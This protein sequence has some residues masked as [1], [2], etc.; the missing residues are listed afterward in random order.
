[1]STDRFSIVARYMNGRTV[2]GYKLLNLSTNR[3]CKVTKDQLCFLVGRKCVYNC[4]GQLYEDKVILRGIGGASL[5]K[6]PVI[7]E[8][9][10]KLSNEEKIHKPYRII[11]CLVNGRNTVGYELVN[12]EGETKRVS[13]KQ[14]MELAEVGLIE[15]ARVQQSNGERIL[16]GVNTN[17]NSLPAISCNQKKR[18]SIKDTLKVLGMYVNSDNKVVAFSLTNTKT[19]KKQQINTTALKQLVHDGYLKEL[20]TPN[21][22]LDTEKIK[23]LPRK[24][25]Q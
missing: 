12:K 15:N 8:S 20:A 22:D 13:R 25:V 24:R 10:K 21:G 17:L 16:R 14:V 2:N 18:E 19:K 3:E 4:Y 5:D 23:K 11:S 1:M 6:L 9:T 7:N